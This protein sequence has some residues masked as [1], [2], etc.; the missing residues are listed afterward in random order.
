ME[1]TV[2]RGETPRE[3]VMSASLETFKSKYHIY[4]SSHQE[5]KDELNGL[6]GCLPAVWFWKLVTQE[7]S[8]SAVLCVRMVRIIRRASPELGDSWVQSWAG[9]WGLWHVQEKLNAPKGPWIQG[10][11]SREQQGKAQEGANLNCVSLELWEQESSSVRAVCT[12]KSCLC[13]V[14][15]C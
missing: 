12:V 6:L 15:L 3:I 9:S 10:W 7:D 14:V 13:R 5:Q 4:S 1:R 11:L 2:K 8:P